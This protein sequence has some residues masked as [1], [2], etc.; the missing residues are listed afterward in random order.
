M[1]TTQM[2]VGAFYKAVVCKDSYQLYC[3][4]CIE[5]SEQRIHFKSVHN[6]RQKIKENLSS[7]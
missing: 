6:S 2:S 4:M 1:Q 5:N 7:Q 3:W